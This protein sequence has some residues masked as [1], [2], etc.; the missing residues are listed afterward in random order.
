LTYLNVSNTFIGDAGAALLA[1]L[2]N[3]KELNI[4]YN[5]INA[6]WAASV[7]RLARSTVRV[8]SRT[9]SC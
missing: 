7:G 2:T 8:I 3:L 5:N 1:A 6:A 9:T 4:S